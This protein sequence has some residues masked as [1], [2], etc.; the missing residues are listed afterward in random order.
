M[1][2][3]TLLVSMVA[4]GTIFA[5]TT[6]GWSQ[7][8]HFESPPL[9]PQERNRVI[10]PY[11]D[12]ASGIVFSVEPGCCPFGDEVVGVVRNFWTSACVPPSNNN[13]KLGTGRSS[14]FESVGLS[15]FPI[16]ATLPFPA[17]VIVSVDIQSRAGSDVQIQLFDE[18]GN[19]IGEAS[20][21]VPSMGTCVTGRPPS[22]RVTLMA[23]AQGNVS[24]ATMSNTS[25][26]VWV[27]DNFTLMAAVPTRASTWGALKALHREE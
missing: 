3:K 5:A 2:Q 26:F 6:D 22:G 14:L 10:D 21:Q 15:A 17:A 12:A 19:V 20:A 18:G 25:G 27:I 4:A 9:G 24:Y 7:T 13:Q 1:I 23:T 16:R 8:V 11:V